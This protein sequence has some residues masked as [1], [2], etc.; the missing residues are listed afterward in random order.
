MTATPKRLLRALDDRD[1][2]VCASTLEN[3][4]SIEWKRPET[5]WWNTRPGLTLNRSVLDRRAE[6]DSTRRCSVEGCLREAYKRGICNTHYI[7]IR[8]HGSPLSLDERK[9][10]DEY[11]A[12][13]IRDRTT[14][15][16]E[17]IVWTGTRETNGY[18]VARISGVSSRAHRLTWEMKHGPIPAGMVIDH[19]C[20]N[21]ACVNTDHLRVVTQKENTR[22]LR[23]A[24][25]DS[26]TGVR[27][28]TWDRRRKKWA[29]SIGVDYRRIHLGRFDSLEDAA[30]AAAEAREFFFGAAS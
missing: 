2:R 7:R 20:H 12:A 16:G 8:K 26:L 24:H 29:A 15:D 4:S 21:R 11:I 14:Q 17:C 6:M 23:G 18:G 25:R 30:K 13:Y 5:V 9:S 3:E 19:L 10:T 22:N 1:G 28:V 27:G